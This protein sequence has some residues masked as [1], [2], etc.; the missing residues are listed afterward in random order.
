MKF[1]SALNCDK[2]KPS[3]NTKLARLWTQRSILP[4]PIRQLEKVK[5][6]RNRFARERPFESKKKILELEC[7]NESEYLFLAA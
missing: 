6:L 2:R 7:K 1:S 4:S 5:V 3:V